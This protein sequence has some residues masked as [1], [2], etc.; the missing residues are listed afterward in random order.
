MGATASYLCYNPKFPQSRHSVL[1]YH[2]G[3][4]GG[5]RTP[6]PIG[7]TLLMPVRS[8][9]LVC[10][11]LLLACV[12]GCAGENPLIAINKKQTREI[13][14]L[15]AAYEQVT[16][17]ESA[18]EQLPAIRESL[19]TMSKIQS[20]LPPLLRKHAKD[21]VR[22]ST[23]ERIK[24]EAKEAERAL[25]RAQDEINAQED[26]P[27]EFFSML[28]LESASF[29]L[30]TRKFLNSIQSIPGL[31]PMPR[32]GDTEII[33]D[34][35]ALYEEHGPTQVVEITVVNSRRTTESD[36]IEA[37]GGDA[38]CLLLDGGGDGTVGV[39]CPVKDYD[40]F[41]ERLAKKGTLSDRFDNR[42]ELT[43]TFNRLAAQPTRSSIERA[44]SRGATVR[45]TRSI[46]PS[47]H[48]D[49]FAEMAENQ[50]K[51]ED[52]RQALKGPGPVRPSDY[53]M[54]A[55][56]MTTGDVFE[57]RDAAKRLLTVDPKSVDDKAIRKQIAQGY[58]TMLR[59]N[60]HGPSHKAALQGLVH[61]GGKYSAPILISLL[62]G[63]KM[64][65]DSALF[66]AL[67]DTKTP[68]AAEALA[69][70]LGNFFSHDEAV[71]AL[72]QIGPIAEPAL[73]ELAPS[74][75]PKISLAAIALL[76]DV[77]T[78]ESYVLLRKAMKSTNREIKAATQ[79]A[80]ARIRR[81]EKAESN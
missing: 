42:R 11:L 73:I 8:S 4:H 34:I 60:E 2:A 78:S 15:T 65:T 10:L 35:L 64:S 62:D 81:R 22:K 77:G 24:K 41:C 28:R 63:D 71:A 61:W 57:K 33:E 9:R 32:G 76:G 17:A 50:K 12:C 27:V 67:V 45:P 80:M 37:A 6:S 38:S 3:G 31:P 26:L 7:E 55:D 74:N 47:Q 43:I 23:T 69:R 66:Q 51:Q 49:F 44:D 21:K 14:K 25:E 20:E 30:A 56:L 1:H 39:V 16:D 68:E 72:R 79:Q 59:E 40:A 58:R 70:K 29:L 52:R 53:A 18:M 5:R 19:Q 13:K 46:T 48:T 75:D 36:L 54:L